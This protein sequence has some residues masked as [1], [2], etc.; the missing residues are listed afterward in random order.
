MHVYIKKKYVYILNI[1]IFNINCMNTYMHVNIFKIYTVCVYLC[2][3][4]K[5]THYTYYVNKIFYFGCD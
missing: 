2:I 4:N 3:K 1:F 5:Y